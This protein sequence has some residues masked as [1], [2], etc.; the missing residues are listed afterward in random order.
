MLIKKK[1]KK[2][3]SKKVSSNKIIIYTTQSC[4]YCHMAMEFFK[5]NNIKYKESKF[6]CQYSL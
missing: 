1:V 2:Y 5:Q 6:L 3:S 4:P